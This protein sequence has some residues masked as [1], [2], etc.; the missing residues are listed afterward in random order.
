MYVWNPRDSSEVVE[1]ACRKVIILV[2]SITIEAL[3]SS[4]MSRPVAS[5]CLFSSSIRN[6][7][8]IGV[9]V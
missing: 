7:L 5:F 4:W 1:V 8:N 2:M 9:M 6:D 3:M